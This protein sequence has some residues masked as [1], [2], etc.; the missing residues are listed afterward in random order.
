MCVWCVDGEPSENYHFRRCTCSAVGFEGQQMTSRAIDDS[1]CSIISFRDCRRKSTPILSTSLEPFINFPSSRS[2]SNCV[3]QFRLEESIRRD[4]I[5]AEIPFR[6]ADE[7]LLAFKVCSEGLFIEPIFPLTVIISSPH[8]RFLQIK[9]APCE[10]VRDSAVFIHYLPWTL[11][12]SESPTLNW[13]NLQL[14]ER[15]WRESESAGGWERGKAGERRLEKHQKV[16]IL[17]SPVQLAK[18][19]KSVQL[20]FHTS[21]SCRVAYFPLKRSTQSSGLSQQQG[22]F[23]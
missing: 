2:H 10:S 20:D 12:F 16:K 19:L 14:G 15:R 18:D 1:P 4:N 22:I 5:S 11:S 9:C 3:L 21:R 6:M 8:V 7:G 13:I 23:I 17:P